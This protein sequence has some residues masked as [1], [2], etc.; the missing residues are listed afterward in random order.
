MSIECVVREVRTRIKLCAIVV[1]LYNMVLV[2]VASD[3]IPQVMK[4]HSP[5]QQIPMRA[6]VRAC[7]RR[8]YGKCFGIRSHNARDMQSN[9]L[10]L[11]K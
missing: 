11:F 3:L 4:Q 2:V 10:T 9:S 1:L 8:I 6:R 7:A 5:L